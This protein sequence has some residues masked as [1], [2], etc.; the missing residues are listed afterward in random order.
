MIFLTL[1]ATIGDSRTPLKTK[2]VSAAEDANLFNTA[3]LPFVS[4]LDVELV[5]MVACSSLAKLDV[6]DGI[7]VDLPN[8]KAMRAQDLSAFGHFLWLRCKRPQEPPPQAAPLPSALQMMMR[9]AS[10]AA[11]MDRQ[12]L[13]LPTL[14]ADTRYDFK[15][16][17]AL[18]NRLKEQN[19]GFTFSDVGSAKSL[20]TA[21]AD[22]LQYC[23]PFD[24]A[25]SDAKPRGI[26]HARGVQLPSRLTTSGLGLQPR[27]H[28]HKSKP[29]D[30]RLSRE[31]LQTLSVSMFRKL[32]ACTWQK[33]P[34]WE[35][36]PGKAFM[37]D[38]KSLI[39]VLAE[40][41]ERMEKAVEQIQVV[42]ASPHPLRN[43]TNAT[44][45]DY[46]D[47]PKSDQPTKDRYAALAE[48]FGKLPA[49][50]FAYKP[51][52]VTDELMGINP[53]S[54]VAIKALARKKF[55]VRAMLR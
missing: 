7:E 36:S 41:A 13:H 30:A 55:I 35:S 14:C 52:M 33:R 27:D 12:Q 39:E 22:T 20:L 45:A 47:R 46:V 54:T 15:I 8:V 3:L 2:L 6:R 11:A 31:K 24:D 34:L 10:T 19:L 40:K 43:P 23:L 51:I 4:E 32:N 42:H 5:E 49:G 16:F 21:V 50:Q 17:N 26:L 29:T 37:D 44:Q 48:E 25:R 53:N 1:R 18:V 9:H 28:G 38:V